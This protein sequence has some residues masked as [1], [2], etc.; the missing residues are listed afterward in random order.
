MLK[1]CARV[2]TS[3]TGRPIR[4]AAIAIH[5]VRAVAAPL[6]PNAP[7]T[8]RE[9]VRTLAMSI[10]SRAATAAL[11][12]PH[13]L[14]RLVHGQPGSFPDA[15]GRVELQRVV[16]LGRRRITAVDFDRGG[17][18]GGIGIAFARI[19]FLALMRL[20]LDANGLHACAC[21]LAVIASLNFV[22]SFPCRL[23]SFRYDDGDNLAIVP[24][25]VALQRRCGRPAPR[26]KL[27]LDLTTDILVSEDIE[28]AW[29]RLRAVE[30]E[31]GEPASGNGAGDE[32]GIGGVRQW[33]VG[34]VARRA[35]DLG[36]TINARHR[37]AEKFGHINGHVSPSWSAA[38][39][40]RSASSWLASARAQ[41]FD[42]QAPACNRCDRG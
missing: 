6:P 37:E 29:N 23:E 3:L 32:I 1:P 40:R 18:E 16:V 19:W 12:P 26:P 14:R 28:H 39:H 33:L 38:M 17:I 5:A 22:R 27:R 8:K 34:R 4:R 42:A 24:D 11:S 9:M 35:R 7:P 13:A 25:A 41:W 30:H 10:P 21:W 31:P 2:G 20:D 36:D 15:G